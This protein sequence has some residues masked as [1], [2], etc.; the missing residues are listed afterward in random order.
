[1]AEHPVIDRER[2]L[3]IDA[4]EEAVPGG[5]AELVDSQ[6]AGSESVGG[7]EGAEGE[8]GRDKRETGHGESVSGGCDKPPTAHR[9]FGRYDDHRGGC[10]VTPDRDSGGPA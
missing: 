4:V 2:P 3:G 10:R 8:R 5:S 7:A 1:M 9:T 6:Q